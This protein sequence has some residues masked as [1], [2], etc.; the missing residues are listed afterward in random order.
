MARQRPEIRLM[1]FGLVITRLPEASTAVVP[2]AQPLSSSA[3]PPGR[4]GAST[5]FTMNQ[6]TST[7]PGAC[8]FPGAAFR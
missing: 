3:A 6:P 5:Q 8:F 7:D 2:A 4:S 1:A